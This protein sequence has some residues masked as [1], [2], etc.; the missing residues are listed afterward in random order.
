MEQEQRTHITRKYPSQHAGSGTNKKTRREI[1]G[2][3]KDIFAPYL[4]DELGVKSINNAV[5]RG[6]FADCLSPWYPTIDESTTD[7]VYAMLVNIANNEQ[8]IETLGRTDMNGATNASLEMVTFIQGC[9]PLQQSLLDGYT[10]L[11][12][13]AE[14]KGIAVLE[15]RAKHERLIALFEAAVKKDGVHEANVLREEIKTAHAFVSTQEYAY[16]NIMATLATLKAVVA[17]YKISEASVSLARSANEIARS[18]VS[19]TRASKATRDEGEEFLAKLAA[20]T[21]GQP[22]KQPRQVPKPIDPALEV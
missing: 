9:A 13:D 12:A 6:E 7:I 5:M 2:D 22:A 21:S 4:I 11:E 1:W 3:V 20:K 8:A 18:K 10:V 14:T 15:A 19:S 16:K 17:R